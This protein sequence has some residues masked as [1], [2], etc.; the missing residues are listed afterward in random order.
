MSTMNVSEAVLSRRSVRAFLD[1]PVPQDVLRRVLD[2]AQ[3]CPSGYNFQPWDA[4]V[5]T[6]EPLQEL[7]RRILT[8]TPQEPEEYQLHPPGI[9]ERHIA[10]RDAITAR[11]MDALGIARDD[12]E[13]RAALHKRNYS[14]F[15]AP[16]ALFA[17][18]PREMG[19][20][21]WGDVGI[22]LQ[23]VMLLLRGEGLDS[24]AQESLYAHARLIKEFIGVSDASHV[25]WCGM[26]IGWR[27]PE[28]PINAYERTRAPLDEVVRFVGFD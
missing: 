14:F 28:A 12:A 20:P 23:T 27:N 5:V 21:Q 15:G 16:T 6:G 22:W 19:L 2:V 25:L 13:A 11:R 3:M 1:A 24:C 26:A 7:S 9:S 8:A 17:L 10:R 18:V 4:V